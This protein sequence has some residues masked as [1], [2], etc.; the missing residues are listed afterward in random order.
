M[1]VGAERRID[2][3]WHVPH[4]YYSVLSASFWRNIS[5]PSAPASVR[6]F[7]I[8]RSRLRRI[9]LRRPPPHVA[10]RP[11][12]A[13]QRD[14]GRRVRPSDRESARDEY[15]RRFR[16][17]VVQ[18][19]DEQRTAG[20]GRDVPVEEVQ[21]CARRKLRRWLGGGVDRRQGEDHEQRR[22]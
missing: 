1:R 11:R 12:V 2:E 5:H 15:D 3:R 13:R 18:T 10:L 17:Q 20:E 9:L 4:A 22:R 7:T 6:S 8:D 19:N 14:R 16:Q 21:K